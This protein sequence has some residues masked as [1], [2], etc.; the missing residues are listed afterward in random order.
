MSNERR[1]RVSRE[2][3]EWLLQLRGEAMLLGRQDI[4]MIAAGNIISRYAD[5][6]SILKQ[7]TRD[8]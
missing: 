4:S 6:E 8:K 2:F 7:W 1:L 3:Y 5:K